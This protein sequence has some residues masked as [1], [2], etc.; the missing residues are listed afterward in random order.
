MP[1]LPDIEAYIAA[2]EPRV[3]GL[4]VERIRLASPFLLR[5][6]T[7]PLC[8][9]EGRTV[10]ELRRV[11]KRIAIGDEGGFAGREITGIADGDPLEIVFAAQDGA[12]ALRCYYEIL[13]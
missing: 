3:M 11:G 2:L 10:R 7:P 12:R 4:P 6:T 13:R 1:E 8:E 9:A 5:T